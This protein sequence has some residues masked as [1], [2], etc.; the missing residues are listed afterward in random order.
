MAGALQFAAPGAI[1]VA[2]VYCIASAYPGLP[3]GEQTSYGGLA[4][5]FLGL[6]SAL[7]TLGGAFFSGA[8]A[9]RYD[10]GHLMRLINL[11]SILATAAVAA[12]LTYAPSTPVALPGP[13]GFYL[14]LWVLLLYPAYALV[15]STS[16]MFRP[17]YNTSIPRFVERAELGTANGLIYAVAAVL[18]LAA[19]LLVGV[20]ISASSAVYSLGVPFALFFGTQMALLLVDIDLS[21]ARKAPTRSVVREAAAGYRYLARRHDLLELTIS[22]LVVNFLAALAL[23][24]VG[25]YLH[26]WLGLTSGFWYGALVA[27]LTAGTA[28]GFAIAPRLRFE[29]RAGRLTI[30]L[31]FF[32]GVLLLAFGLVRS[33]WFALPIAFVY[34][35]MPGI[36]MTIFLSTVQATVPD[37]MMGRVFSAD[38]V[39]SYALVPVGQ[40]A[41][42]LLVVLVGVQGTYL[43]AGGAVAF[44]SLIMISSFGALRRLGYPP[45]TPASA[46]SPS[47]A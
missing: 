1:L 13:P 16:T 32:M 28:V 26:G 8:L 43:T 44:F 9:D 40:F 6:S 4:L 18:S 34:G 39:G 42:G 38:E 25:V 23:V 47:G 27:V 17:A 3:A 10:R 45:G 19:S 33:V 41:G 30:L 5:A 20:V 24:E 35:L 31:I 29:P 21:V 36:L 12:D 14:P 37:E 2:L 46:E 7:P 15:I 22:A 11:L